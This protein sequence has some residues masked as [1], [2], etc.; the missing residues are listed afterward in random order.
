MTLPCRP[1]LPPEWAPQSGVLLTWPHKHGDW[2]PRLA[3]VE[4]VFVDIA[5]AIARRERVVIACNDAEHRAHVDAL[6]TAA[7]VDKARVL[8]GVAPSNDTWAR[9]HG[10]IT[11]LC[12]NKPLLFDFGFNGWGGKYRHDADNLIT[13]RLH[14]AGIFGQ[15]PIEPMELILEGGSIEVDGSGTLLT[16][17]QCLLAPT[18]NPG[19]SRA[20]I[21]HELSEWLGLKRVLWLEH[22]HLAGDDTDSHIDTLAR[23]CDARTIAYITCD[24]PTDEHYDDLKAMEAELK[25]FRGADGSAYRLVPLPWPRAQFD[26]DARLPATYAN[27]LIINDAV[28]VPTYRDPA[29]SV[30]LERL[31][32]CFPDR[33]IVGIDCAP[34]IAQYG[35]LHCLTMQLPTGVLP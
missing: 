13:Q 6:L 3:N 32:E 34:I 29:D 16:T 15:T 9:D 14:Q 18:R 27:F 12:R 20:Q 17:T 8:L 31:Q 22:G 21:E 28:L 33:E 19:L 25:E 35:S 30:A 1:Y 24:D 5:G 23:F 10:P 11:V 7:G 26:D 4:P 2:A